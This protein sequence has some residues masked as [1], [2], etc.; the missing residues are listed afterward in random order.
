MIFTSESAHENIK[1]H[2]K[3]PIPW[4][5]SNVDN[6]FQQKNLHFEKFQIE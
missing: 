1:E 3:E 5:S 4:T 2:K 6:L